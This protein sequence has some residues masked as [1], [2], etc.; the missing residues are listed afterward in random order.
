MKASLAAAPR[1]ALLSLAALALLGGCSATPWQ[2]GGV[3]AEAACSALMAPVP[4]SAIGLPSGGAVIESAT[5][6][7]GN[8]LTLTNPLPFIPP[9][10]E[11][12]VQ[13]ATPPYCKVVGAIQPVDPKAPSIRFQVNLPSRWNGRS[14]QLGGGGFNGVLVTATGLP[15][16]ARID[17]PSPLA[18]GFV[19]VGTDSGHQDL[20]VEPLQAFALNDEAL[21]N[22]AHAAYKKVRDL[23]VELMKRR[24]GQ[25]PER[26]YFMG[27][28]EGGRE[29]LAMAQR[30]PQD[31]DGI[32]A[33]APVINWVGL[34]TADVRLGLAQRGEGWLSPADVMLVHKAV[35]SACDALDWRVDGI[36]GNPQLCGAQF[37]PASLLCREGKTPACLNAAQVETLRTLH[38]PYE[39]SFPLANGVRSYPGW[40][41]G[42]EGAGGTGPVGGYVSWQTGTAPAAHPVSSTSS[43]GW[44]YGSGAIQYF[45]LRDGTADLSN[46][47]PEDHAQRVGEI[48]RLMDATDPDLSAFRAHGGKLVISEH[49]ADYAQSPYAGIAYYRSVVEKMGQDP[50]D[51]FMRLYT[52]PGADHVGT[53]APVGVDMLDTLVTWVES[54]RAP[55]DLVQ[56]SLDPVPP[57]PVLQSRPMCRWPATLRYRGHGEPQRASSYQ[58]VRSAPR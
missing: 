20:R 54:G 4:A 9:P 57:F 42:G 31:F 56:V 2:R 14:L 21:E 27:S 7:P 49:M 16:S 46:Y 19:T 40:A 47:K 8:A 50:V 38:A 44:L 53:G 18:R 15:P 23:S 17:Q 24:Y 41:W 11:A 34:H 58:C 10:P 55:L 6:L 25:G 29:G 26:M 5:L 43:R 39:F 32:F 30:Y 52:T 51:E 35:L 37:D 45:V 28:S 33:R 1:A 36:V 13:P 48:S 12:V 22:F 3:D